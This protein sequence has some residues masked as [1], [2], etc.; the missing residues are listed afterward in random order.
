[1]RM[2]KKTHIKLEK[3]LNDFMLGILD[4]DQKNLW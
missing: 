1:M 3:E 4:F 2:P